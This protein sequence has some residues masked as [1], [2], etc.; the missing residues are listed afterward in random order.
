MGIEHPAITRMNRTGH[1]RPIPKIY[2]TDALG[3]TALGGQEILCIED[4]YFLVDGLDNTAIEVLEIMG[5][6]YAIAE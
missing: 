3:N 2:G 6:T 1:Y 4:T 5:A